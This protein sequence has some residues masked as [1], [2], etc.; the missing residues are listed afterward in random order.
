MSH[1]KW[2]KY[3]K[4]RESNWLWFHTRSQSIILLFL[5]QHFF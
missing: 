5:S 1:K 3:K 2:T 4:H